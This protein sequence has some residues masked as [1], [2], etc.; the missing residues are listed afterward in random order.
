MPKGFNGQKR[1][2]DLI[3]CA[4]AVAQIAPGEDEDT[5]FAQPAKRKS[6]EAGGKARAEFLSREKRQEIAKR[7]LLGG[8]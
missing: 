8:R 3:G 4:V 2:S 1:P 7:R 6:G 5:R